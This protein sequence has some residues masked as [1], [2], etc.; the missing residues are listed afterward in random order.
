MYY[1]TIYVHDMQCPPRTN[2]K[3]SYPQIGYV[4]KQRGGLAREIPPQ[5]GPNNYDSETES[6]E[7]T[8]VVQTCFIHWL[9]PCVDNLRVK[10]D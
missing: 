10:I 6:D 8:I 9:N 3:C 4:H 2:I 1:H 7:E 5:A